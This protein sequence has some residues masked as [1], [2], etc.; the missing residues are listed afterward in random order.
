[1]RAHCAA[2]AGSRTRPR[3]RIVSAPTKCSLTS[4]S[5]RVVAVPREAGHSERPNRTRWIAVET[6]A[7]D[8]HSRVVGPVGVP[9]RECRLRLV[10]QPRRQHAH[11]AQSPCHERTSRHDTTVEPGT[12]KAFAVRKP[13]TRLADRPVWPRVDHPTRWRGGSPRVRLLSRSRRALAQTGLGLR[14]H[15]SRVRAGRG[16]EWAAAAPC[17]QVTGMLLV[18]LAETSARGALNA[19]R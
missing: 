17:R 4:L 18:A 14:R 7:R 9:Q 13:M 15:T 12:R 5:A 2:E 16:G 3:E 8:P 19:Q 1:M 11:R 10:E 6:P